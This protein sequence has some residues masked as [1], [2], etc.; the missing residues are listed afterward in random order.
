MSTLDSGAF[1]GTA[2]YNSIVVLMSFKDRSIY[3][4]V[5]IT[6]ENDNNCYHCLH[7]RLFQHHCDGIMGVVASQITSLTIVYSTV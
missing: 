3:L 7:V 2:Q 5:N 1:K 4:W 6:N